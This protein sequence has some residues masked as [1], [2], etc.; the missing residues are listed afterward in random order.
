MDLR[1]DNIPIGGSGRVKRTETPPAS[2]I[3]G[4]GIGMISALFCWLPVVGL[5]AGM[6]GI[7]ISAVGLS[8]KKTGFGVG[9]MIISIIGTIISLILMVV[10]VIGLIYFIR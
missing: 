6:L 9:G 5:I 8:K 1:D 10:D 7:S 4:L 2:S 3:V